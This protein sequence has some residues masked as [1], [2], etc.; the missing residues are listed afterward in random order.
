[1]MEIPSKN[2]LSVNI[3]GDHQSHEQLL[4]DIQ[5]RQIAAP[6]WELDFTIYTPEKEFRVQ[7]PLFLYPEHAN[8]GAGEL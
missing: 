5:Q 1:M 6:I 8:F 4:A 2:S 7:H 3:H